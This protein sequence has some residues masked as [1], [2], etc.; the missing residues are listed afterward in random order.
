LTNVVAVSQCDG[1]HV[2]ALIGNGPPINAASIQDVLKTD[3]TLTVS[4]PSRPG[5]VYRLE[6]KDGLDDSI[7]WNPFPL[8]AGTGKIIQLSDPDPGTG[9]RFYRVRRW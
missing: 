7:P 8:V 3:Q 4:I 2:M 1:Y 5:H 6:A 9:Q